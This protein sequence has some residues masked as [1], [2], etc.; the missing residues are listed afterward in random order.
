MSQIANRESLRRALDTPNY[1]L[2]GD[3]QPRFVAFC[4]SNDGQLA[5]TQ[6]NLRE[7]VVPLRWIQVF[8]EACKAS[9]MALSAKNGRK[10]FL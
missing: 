4:A 8:K 3:D 1:S 7:Q 6:R 5:G 10:R 2:G 9:T